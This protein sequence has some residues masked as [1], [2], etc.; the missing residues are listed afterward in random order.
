MSTTRPLGSGTKNLT[1]NV[2]HELYADVAAL[3]HRSGVRLGEYVRAVLEFAVH[4][5]LVVGSLDED[6]KAWDAAVR[7]GET[8]RPPAIVVLNP[9]T[10]GLIP[11]RDTGKHRLNE[12]PPERKP[13]MPSH[14]ALPA[15]TG[16]PTGSAEEK[17]PTHSA[18]GFGPRLKKVATKVAMRKIA[19]ADQE[20]HGGKPR[21]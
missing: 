19:E 5:Q 15:S 12:C 17:T 18:P 20:R 8:P 21:D 13:A 16:A 14:R 7:K 4:H 1:A 9:P 3:Q 11:P 2:S 10:F 6:L